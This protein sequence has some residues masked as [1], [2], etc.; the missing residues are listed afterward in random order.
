MQRTIMVTGATSGI[1]KETARE[2]AIRGAQVAVVGRNESKAEATVTA[3]REV[4]GND[5]VDYL[6]ADF[7]SLEDVRR[8]A[9]QFK[10]RYGRLDVLVN[11]AGAMF[12]RRQ[13][14]VD[15]YEMTFAVNHLAPFLLTNLLLE[16]MQT[17]APARIVTVASDAHDGA[18]MEFDNLQFEKDYSGM[19]AYGRSKLANILFSYELARRLEGSTV[20]SNAMHPGFVSTGMGS[21]NLPRWLAGVLPR[22]TRP[23]ARDVARGAETVVYLV[24][25]SQVETVS[26]L[27]FMDKQPIKS[28]PIPY[29]E[30]LARQLWQIS[31]E[32]VDLS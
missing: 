15:G 30:A 18:T 26:G 1:G 10:Q 20:T 16:T 9:G 12:F 13:E 6:L 24:D 14:S 29:D 5:K 11:N 19:K 25:S 17:S 3:I 7:A 22:V 8:L 32:M 28:S 31:A 2:L 23:F 4:T 27:Y 21:N